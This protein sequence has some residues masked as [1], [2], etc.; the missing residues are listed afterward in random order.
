LSNEVLA[1]V[2]MVED[3]ERGR[4]F[5]VQSPSA[6]PHNQ[7]HSLFECCPAVNVQAILHK[8]FHQADNCSNEGG[9]PSTHHFWSTKSTCRKQRHSQPSFA[10]YHNRTS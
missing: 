7:S 8:E 2:E 6:H 10:Q 5:S 3:G 9:A 1:Q 4:D